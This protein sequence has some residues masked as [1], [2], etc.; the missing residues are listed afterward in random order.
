MKK[1]HCKQIHN[2]QHISVSFAHMRNNIDKKKKKKT[3]LKLKDR[4]LLCQIYIVNVS[5]AVHLY[6]F[7]KLK[8]NEY[9]E[10]FILY[11]LLQTLT[12]RGKSKQKMKKE[13][14]ERK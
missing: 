9:C 10:L 12:R 2:Y 3:R 7:A 8:K 14:S 5:C 6:A 1:S 13:K 11:Y 4:M